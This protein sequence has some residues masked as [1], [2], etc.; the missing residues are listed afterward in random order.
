MLLKESAQ[1][2]YYAYRNTAKIGFN[3]EVLC[4]PSLKVLRQFLR[5]NPGFEQVP[6][7][8]LDFVEPR[9][10]KASQR[11]PYS[12]VNYKGIVVGT[13]LVDT[14]GAYLDTKWL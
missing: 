2:L 9:Q 12:I 4:V 7:N 1:R 14:R 3:Y 10:L 13:V 6:G 5:E 11:N 8:K